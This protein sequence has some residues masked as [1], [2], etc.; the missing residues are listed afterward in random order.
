MSDHD[1]HSASRLAGLL[2]LKPDEIRRTLLASLFHL[3]FVAT[4]V[5]VK[6][7][8]NALVVA[9]Y[10]AEALPPLYIATALA[11]GGAAW[12]AALA[13]RGRARRLPRAGL[14][15]ATALL[16][17]LAA[18][19]HLR[20]PVAVIALYLFGETFA[21]LVSIR[22][23][24]AASELFDARASKRTFGILGAAGM[25]GAILAGLMAQLL[26][27][28]LGAVGLLPP[29]LVLLVACTGFSLAVRRTR[30]SEVQQQPAPA[31]IGLVR[32]QARA[33][34]Q[35]DR[36]PRA[37]AAL[38]VLLATLT[39]LADYLFRLRA[40]AELGEA[41][42]AS[43]FGALNLW[44]GVVAV[45]FQ[46]GLAGRV[47]ERWGIFRYLLVTPGCSA[48]TAVAC[49][50][51]PGIAPAFTLR[52][53]ES[54]GS[55]SLNPAAFQLLYGPVPDAIR[56]QIRAAID[57]VTKKVGFAAGGALLLL[58]GSHASIEALVAAVVAVVALVALVLTRTRKL[59][60]AAIE[61]RLARAT[62]RHPT[63]LRSAEARQALLRSLRDTDPVRL[64]TAV[65]LLA[66]DP[67]FDPVPHLHGLLT[68]PHDRVRLAAIRL[69]RTRRVT[70]AAPHLERLIEGDTPQ[71]RQ[72]AA[73][74]LAV[75]SPRRAEQVLAPL[76]ASEDPALAGAAVAALLPLEGRTGR[77]TQA[78]LRRLDDVD[79]P[80][81]ER[82][83][84][85]RILGRLGP[86]VHAVRLLRYLEDPSPLV[87]RTACD[88]AGAT[89]ELPLVPVLVVL[90]GDRAVR[91][92]A[93]R[94]LA[95]YGDA[96]VAELAALLDDRNR[97]LALRLEVPR[98]LR[99]IGTA[100]AARAL[101][102]SNIQ[103][104]AY[105]R[106]RIAVNL[107]R[108]HEEH[109]AIELD[110]QR[111]REAT[112]RRLDAYHYYL[113]LYRDLEVGLPAGAPLVRAVGD[114]LQQNLEV[115]F[116]LLQLTLPGSKIVPAWRRFAGGDARERAYA[117][118][119]IDHL[120]D[121][122]LKGRVLP[123]LERYHRLPEPWGGVPGVAARAP[124]RVL[125]I[126]VARD[127]VLR[128]IAI[129]TAIRTW[130]ENPPLPPGVGED[131]MDAREIERVFFLEGVEIFGRCDVDDL[132]ALAA[133][134][135]EREYAGGETI[136]SEGDPGDALYV[137]L[138]GGVQFLKGGV[139]VLQ[140]GVRD[141]FGESSLLDGAPRPVSAVA[142]G[143]EV[144]V[145]AVDRHDFLDLVSDRP[146]L[147]RGIFT[148]VSRHLRQVLDRTAKTG[149]QDPALRAG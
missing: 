11:T 5:L 104:H 61:R 122:E 18:A 79:A 116:R 128:S 36:Y 126:A 59:Y 77:A 85:A 106:Y 88:A 50:F 17:G 37:L 57:G 145:L 138:E 78:L 46:L 97:P 19:A 8:S 112:L 144:R 70:P 63:Q 6:S 130:P 101:L 15:L 99:G 125:E 68:H 42:M 93:R 38:M 147:L 13:D 80:P 140:I 109:P 31:T 44:M 58:L 94:A 133:I 134:A 60:V 22:F 75:L 146:E 110:V 10:Q 45:L 64:L 7:A 32:S 119:L 115:V 118:E 81:E 83:E 1:H 71:V 149:K 105:L 82:R 129:H 89:R 23:W 98:V 143:R 12:L 24:S 28:R 35:G 20:L 41:E 114:R 14:V 49:L 30:G 73:L 67:R 39:A 117:I 96:V 141:S 91:S 139:E 66:E 62:G 56:P 52:L 92:A 108:L 33:Y 25:T 127:E 120:L 135:R 4:V 84:T 100:A 9:R 95:A 148:A 16:A 26:G 124:A 102:F 47:L 103:E 3:A 29:A 131:E 87:R 113:P 69:A 121:D 40:G 65:S 76:L 72:E 123:L 53:V 48:A 74:A 86:S 43:L 21:T 142:L 51:V 111:A 90:L 27:A 2:G 34:L 132:M 107:S 54:A 55:L 137:V 136:F